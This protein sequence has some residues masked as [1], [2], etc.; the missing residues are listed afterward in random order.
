MPSDDPCLLSLT[1]LALALREG[2][3]SSEKA[4]RAHLERIAAV[5][6]K[7]NAV[8]QVRAEAALAEAREAD[9][10]PSSARGLLHGVPVTIKDSLDTAGIVTTGGTQ[11]R[12]AY[13]PREDATVVK[14]LRAAGAIVMGKTNTPDLTLGYE[15]NNLVYGR[16]NN[17]FDPERTSGGSSGGAAAIVA[18]GGS[19]LDVGSDTGGS[20]RLPAH[21]CGVAG[22]KPTAGRVPRTGHIIDYEGAGQFLTHIGPLA[23]H[24]DDLAFALWILAG[25]DGRDPHVP[26]VLLRDPAAVSVDG[27]RVAF[28]TRLPP[29][30]PTGETAAVVERAVAALEGAGARVRPWGDVP[31][32]EKLYEKYMAVL[33]GDG[34]A[35]VSRILERWGTVDSPLRERLRRSPALPSSETTALFEWLDR[36]SSRMLGLFADHDAIVCP[37]NAGPAPR[38]GTFDRASAAYTQVFN[39]TGWPSTA[40]RA[41]TSKEG[42]PIGVQVVAHPWREDV[43]LALAGHLEKTLGPFPGPVL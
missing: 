42:L 13:V 39:V 43:S 27:L 26:P 22:L 31:D 3:L 5:N 15:T 40:V 21:F 34:G 20:I 14:R 29:L 1:A 24:V 2:G 7:L 41:G 23:R 4:T 32:S 17:P 28:F 19:P 16:T 18:A 8:V 33:Y 35:A 9:R 38:H 37:V 36:W 11:G 10:L 25:P 12:A 6:P 30:E